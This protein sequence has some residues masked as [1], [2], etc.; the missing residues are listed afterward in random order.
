MSEVTSESRFW[1]AY[2]GT[3]GKGS[4][5]LL[6]RDVVVE[7][8]NDVQLFH[9]G[10][11]ELVLYR[12]D[13]VRTKLKKLSDLDYTLVPGVISAYFDLRRRQALE[14]PAH[15]EPSHPSDVMDRSLN[16]TCYD[17][18]GSGFEQ[19]GAFGSFVCRTCL[20]WGRVE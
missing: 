8:S 17:C 13:I 20:G 18:S 9:F 14:H 5:V 15:P 19:D 2:L 11:N 4:I 6:D 7:I 12:K 3:P 16:R 10:R 1:F